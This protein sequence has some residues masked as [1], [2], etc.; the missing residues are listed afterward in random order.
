MIL[1]GLGSS[2]LEFW[3]VTV[4]SW[5]V[6]AACLQLNYKIYSSVIL[7]YVGWGYNAVVGKCKLYLCSKTEKVD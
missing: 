2:C 5:V 6:V 7:G 3:I 4:V 1:L